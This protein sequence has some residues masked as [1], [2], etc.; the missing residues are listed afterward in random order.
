MRKTIH[1]D[2]LPLKA[3]LEP[4]GVFSTIWAWFQYFLELI[5][6]QFFFIFDNLSFF[7]G[8]AGK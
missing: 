2:S 8:V 3:A 7:T 6:R 1:V 5:W 4:Y